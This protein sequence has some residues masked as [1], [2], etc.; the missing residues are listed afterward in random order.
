[1]Q[2]L[3]IPRGERERRTQKALVRWKAPESKELVEDALRTAGRHDL[4]T[5]FYA[6]LKRSQHRRDTARLD[7]DTCG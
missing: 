5:K 2:E 4:L 3:H 1:M 6:A 7:L